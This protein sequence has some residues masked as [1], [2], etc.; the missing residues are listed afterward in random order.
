MSYPS[1]EQYTEALQ[2]PQLDIL[3]AELKQGRLK[4]TGLGLPLALCGGFALTYTVEAS[5]KK[6]ALRCFHKESRELEKRYAAIATKLKQLTSSYFLPFE[7]IRD[8]IRIQGAAYPIV[9]MAWAQGQTLAE[10]LENEHQNKS[11]LQRLRQSLNK[12]AEFIERNQIAHGDIQPENLMVSANGAEIQL[13]DYDGMFV[14]TLRGAKATELGQVNFQHPQRSGDHFNQYLDRFSFIT[15]DIAI[16]ALIASPALWNIS[17]SEPS[18]VV[19]RR[20]DFIDPGT[21]LVFQE[22]MKLPG[23]KIHAENLAKVAAG[24]F[25]SIP[26]LSDFLQG[27][28]ISNTLI[29]FEPRT[30]PA[31]A[32]Y[33]GAYFVCDAANY[34]QVL[35][36][37]GNRIELIGKVHSIKQG[38]GQNRKPYIFINFSD[39]RGRAIKLAI[40]SDGLKSIEPNVPNDTW[41]GK[42]LSITGLVDPPFNGQA[43]SVKY[44]H[45]SITINAKGQI[46]QIPEN[47]ARYRLGA[48]GLKRAAP[49]TVNRNSEILQN[50]GG[51]TR[52]TITGAPKNIA[53]PHPKQVPNKS[54]NQQLLD[55]M[56]AQ[57]PVVT[58][59]S[60][61]PTVSNI[62]L[63]PKS[64]SPAGRQPTAPKKT[65]WG[66]EASWYSESL[67][68][69][70]LLQPVL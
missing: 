5:G 17:R 45:L 59:P 63:K 54:A 46:Q 37:V 38:R 9:K 50:M 66:K 31:V 48:T 44:T 34:A 3:D 33:Q 13:I 56:R 58:Q 41:V 47:E 43:G 7:F 64:S 61:G 20:N 15:L 8:G 39:W 18:A 53:Q 21:S 57:T 27:K 67:L 6:F 12:L 51:T 40:W 35:A 24:V 23:L 11:S 2:S 49:T 55:K 60:A 29:N 65:S 30:T 69:P 52:P 22:V 26:S 19:F 25:N 10:F 28:G 62:P 36:Q 42:W 68:R 32:N 1:L 16:Q 14:E 70:P 4:T